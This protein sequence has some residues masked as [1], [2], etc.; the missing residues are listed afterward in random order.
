MLSHVLSFPAYLPSAHEVRA[1]LLLYDRMSTIVPRVDQK[2]VLDRDAISSISGFIPPD[3][4]AFFDP[5]YAYVDWFGNGKTKSLVKKKSRSI[6]R[7]DGYKALSELFTVD[8][9]G[10]FQP[11][12]DY[13]IAYNALINQG[14]R[15]LALQKF[16]PDLLQMLIDL[17][18]AAKLP[19]LEGEQ[20][21]VLTH[22]TIGSFILGQI[23]RHFASDEVSPL[24]NSDNSFKDCLFDGSLTATQQRSLLLGVTINV[25]VPS[26][27]ESVSGDDFASLRSALAKQRIDINKLL[28]DLLVK[29]NLDS[30]RDAIT[31]KQKISDRAA[32]IHKGITDAEKCIGP[33]ILINRTL[34][35]AVSLFGGA[36][37]FAIGALPGAVVGALTPTIMSSIPSRVSTHFYPHGHGSLEEFAAIRAKVG[38][39]GERARYRQ[40]VPYV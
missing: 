20:D 2:D 6:I 30:E 27:I 12:G 23:A 33:R 34:T 13:D 36:A 40:F 39:A 11:A 26:D 38:R 9:S 17:K 32:D 15:P 10:Y 7:G 31:F 29:M 24:A 25:A 16:P 35:L 21:P 3:A 37:G 19:S 5:T 28:Q 1:N 14:W 4:F 22:P 18:L 8:G